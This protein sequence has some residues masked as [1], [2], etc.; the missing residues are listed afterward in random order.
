MFRPLDRV[1]SQS[2]FISTQL[3]TILIGPNDFCSNFCDTDD[4]DR[5]VE[6]HENDLV[7]ALRSLRDHLPRTMVNLIT[8]PGRDY[9]KIK[10]SSSGIHLFI[11][12]LDLSILTELRGK[13]MECVSI[14]HVECPCLFGFRY[15]SKRKLYFKTIKRWQQVSVKVS[16]MDEFNKE[17]SINSIVKRAVHK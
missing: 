7:I 4:L 8:P 12:S 14:H 9:A 5:T 1:V 10:C 2:N 16:N 6:H 15:R 3:I 13:P 11:N 17:V